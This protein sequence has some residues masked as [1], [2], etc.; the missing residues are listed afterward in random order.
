MS[1]SLLPACLQ[2]SVDLIGV[3]TQAGPIGSVK[4]KADNSELLRRDV[5][6]TDQ[7]WE[8]LG[9]SLNPKP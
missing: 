4:R 3:V 2:V 6:L 9:F 5:T 1:F 7:R 8:P